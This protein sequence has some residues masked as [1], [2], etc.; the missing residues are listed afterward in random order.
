MTTGSYAHHR[1]ASLLLLLL[2]L[3][4][5]GFMPSTPLAPRSSLG[6]LPATAAPEAAVVIETLI[7]PMGDDTQLK[8]RFRPENFKALALGANQVR[9]VNI[10]AVLG[11][12]VDSGGCDGLTDRLPGFS[13]ST[14]A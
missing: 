7:L 2:P 14:G 6:P 1:L 8:I 9:R 12:G 13:A 4:A 10:G 5:L 11:L 3:A